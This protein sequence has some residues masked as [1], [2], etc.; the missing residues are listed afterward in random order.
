MSAGPAR[1]RLLADDRFQFISDHY[2]VGI[3]PS[4]VEISLIHPTAHGTRRLP[5]DTVVMIGYNHP[6]RELAEALGE[7]GPPVYV[8][9]DAAGSRT[10]RA[11]IKDATTTA[12]GLVG[13]R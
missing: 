5:A 9:G 8:V 1:E 4:D 13:A 2:V 12:R 11:A 6:N 10:L 3:T 7:D